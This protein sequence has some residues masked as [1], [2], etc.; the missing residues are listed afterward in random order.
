MIE[1]LF[2]IAAVVAIAAT[3]GYLFALHLRVL[4]VPK[5]FPRHEV[6]IRRQQVDLSPTEFRLLSVL[7]KNA[8]QVMRQ[9][10]LLDHVWGPRLC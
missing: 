8:G 2:Q 1:S 10:Q 3:S 5:W 4:P 7:T 9:G 6:I